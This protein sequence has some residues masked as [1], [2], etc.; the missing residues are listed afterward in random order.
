MKIHY[1]TLNWNKALFVALR[2]ELI[3][4]TSPFLPNDRVRESISSIH[5]IVSPCV[6]LGN[7]VVCSPP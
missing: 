7:V 5:V 3:Q 2:H 6:K 1:L 4:L